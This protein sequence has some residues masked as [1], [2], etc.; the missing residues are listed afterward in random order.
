M[1]ENMCQQE[2]RWSVK[3]DNTF[4]SFPYFENMQFFI[5]L[6]ELKFIFQ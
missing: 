4:Q 1:I 6:V 5:D 2:D 3:P